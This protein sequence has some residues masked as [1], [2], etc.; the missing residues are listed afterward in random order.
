MS[1]AFCLREVYPQ[2]IDYDLFKAF[3][4]VENKQGEKIIRRESS[5]VMR[6]MCTI[7][8]PTKH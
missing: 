2:N 1:R 6:I 7:S 3:D 8:L 5:H 4:Y